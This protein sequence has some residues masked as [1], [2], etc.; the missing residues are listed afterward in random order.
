MS[1]AWNI[2]R[3]CWFC[4]RTCVYLEAHKYSNYL[5]RREMFLVEFVDCKCVVFLKE[6]VKWL[7][8]FWLVQFFIFIILNCWILS[9]TSLCECV[10]VCAY[11]DVFTFLSSDF[12][13]GGKIIA[14]LISHLKISCR[15][16]GR[17]FWDAYWNST[18]LCQTK[19]WIQKLAWT[20]ET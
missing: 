3:D 12:G 7:C 11:I 4:V 1:M 15:G 10:C 20:E 18:H 5:T 6:Q 2:Q 9:I 17:N 8:F 19:R 13:G 14:T 16:F